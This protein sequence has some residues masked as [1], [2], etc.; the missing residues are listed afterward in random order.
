MALMHSY[1]SKKRRKNVL[2]NL[3]LAFRT[4]GMKMNLR[5]CALKYYQTHYID[6]LW[7]FFLP[8][9]N[10]ENFGIFHR[11]DG[12][13]HVDDALKNGRGCILVHGHFGPTQMPLFELGLRG[14]HV[15][16][17]GYHAAD[18]SYIGREVALRI[19]KKYEGMMPASIVSARQFLRPILA[20]L[21]KNQV[22]MTAGDGT[23]GGRFI[24]R[25]IPLSFLG[26]TMHFPTGPMALVRKTGAPI[27]PIFTVNDG[28]KE[29]TTIIEN[30]LMLKWSGNKE[31]DLTSNTQLFASRLESYVRQYPYLWHFW[32]EYEEVSYGHEYA[33][34]KSH[35]TRT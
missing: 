33:N 11:I 27:L 10:R 5:T 30:P 15:T 23:G 26:R 2:R 28:D 20:A 19:R 8:K 7:I 24:G 12:I 31:Q 18:L 17:I 1:I 21:R 13:H 29:Y 6:R 34:A 4:H 14:Y 35:C 32:E 3:G 25:S 22:V 9:L 16:Q